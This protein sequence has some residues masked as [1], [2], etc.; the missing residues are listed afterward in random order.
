MASILYYSNF[1]EHSKKLLQTLSKTQVNK[2]L[3]F[4]CIDKRVK[5]KDGKIYLILEN[6]QKIVM[7]ENVTKVPALLLL[8]Q[9]YNVLY[10][11]SIYE[12]LKPRQEAV[13]RQATS[14]NMEPMAFSLGGF[15]LGFGSGVVSDNYS[16]LD[17]N[18]D[19]LNAKGDGG[20]RQM[21]SYFGLQG[22]DKIETPKDDHDYKQSKTSNNLTVEQ[23]QQQ[24]DQELN[25]LS[26]GKRPM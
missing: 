13:T 18:A 25:S 24:R 26:S 5:E 9:N 19:D 3:H 2:D 17:Q 10:G 1:C 8:N 20:L 6:G 15:G 11:D 21:H 4:M 12:H 16:F 14:N 7:P 23:L 22:S